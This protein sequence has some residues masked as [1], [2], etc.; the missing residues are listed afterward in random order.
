MRVL[1]IED[2]VETAD[3]IMHGLDAQGHVPTVAGDGV[4]ALRRAA[5]D[6]WDAI[7]LDRLLPEL[8]GISVLRRLRTGGVT[9]PVL[10]LTALGS[11]RDR[12]EGLDAGADDYLVKPFALEEL[13]ARLN[14]LTRRRA[15]E[16][17]VTALI[18]GNLAMNLLRREVHYRDQPVLIQAREFSLLE[19]LM[20]NAGHVVTKAMLLQ[21]VW[22]FHFAPGTNIVETH[23]SRLRTKLA[24]AGAAHVIET[25]RGTGYIVRAVD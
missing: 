22:G 16:E 8:D 19:V 12:V 9:T 3:F 20:R 23:M 18:C 14:A 21:E 11:V 6:G 25:I 1:V 17:A 24:H 7:I 13:T 4:T 15:R 2:D 5:R 10:L